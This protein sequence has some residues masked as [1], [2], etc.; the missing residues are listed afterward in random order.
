MR[1]LWWVAVFALVGGRA[2]AQPSAWATMCEA[3]GVHGIMA[4]GA[5]AR[6][7][8]VDA[9]QAAFERRRSESPGMI[10]DETTNRLMLRFIWRHRGRSPLEIGQLLQQAC[11]RD[12]P[13]AAGVS[14]AL[15][16]QYCGDL[17]ELAR[18]MAHDRDQG[19]PFERAIENMPPP[20]DADTFVPRLVYARPWRTPDRNWFT[21]HER[22]MDVGPIS[23]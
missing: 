1:A 9:L 14:Y 11:E 22:C 15:R 7:A 13:E 23:P 6:G 17:S 19:V 5:T 4:A 18:R 3:Y 12:R 20:F 16:A 2:E 10:V 8:T 21:I